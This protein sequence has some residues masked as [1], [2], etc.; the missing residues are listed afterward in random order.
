MSSTRDLIEALKRELKLAGL[1]YADAARH[2]GMAESSV[3]RM[4]A[5]QG[6]LPLS[7]IDELLALLK[8][9]FAD[10]ARRVADAQPARQELSEP[11]EQA[12]VADPKLLL[13]ASC[14]LSQWSFEQI[15]ATYRYGEAEAVS[16]LAQLDRLGVIELRPLN[17]Y[18]L[19]VAKTFRW[20]PDGPVMR[21]FRQHVVQD[22]FDGNFA[23]EGERLL[24]V[25]GQLGDA[26]VAAFNERLERVAADCAQQHLAD[27]RLPAA[28]RKP[29]SLVIAMR[30]WWFAPFAALRR[31][32][33]P[34][35]ARR[36]TI[37]M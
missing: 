34:A 10:L 37:R 12:V 30:S 35:Q 21:F 23:A 17:R 6:D 9:D 25:H 32:P 2:L 3:K 28:Q 14:C 22:Y 4:F 13:M 1:T 7:R 31:E 19:L 27:Q 29:Y 18:R 36:R 33:E 24:L 15:L 11:Q 26:Q 8:M 5:A 16:M 20:R